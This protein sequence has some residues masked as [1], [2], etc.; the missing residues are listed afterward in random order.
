M[1][2]SDNDDE[3]SSI[4]TTT[5]KTHFLDPT[6]V[7]NLAKSIPN[8]SHVSPPVDTNTDGLSSTAAEDDDDANDTHGNYGIDALLSSTTKSRE[9]GGGAGESYFTSLSRR[10]QQTFSDGE[11]QQEQQQQEKQKQQQQQQ[12][13]ERDDETILSFLVSD[14]YSIEQLAAEAEGKHSS[15]SELEGAGI[16]RIDVYCRSGT[17]CT[18]RVIQTST[19]ST[20]DAAGS[21]SKDIVNDHN[22]SMVDE[23]LRD[24][25]GAEAIGNPSFLGMLRTPPKDNR[26]PSKD[27]EDHSSTNTTGGGSAN[28]TQVRRIVRRK[29]TLDALRRILEEPPH[30]PEINESIIAYN[31]DNNVPTTSG[32]G[33]DLSDNDTDDNSYIKTS[34][35]EHTSRAVSKLL[36]KRQQKRLSTKKFSSKL[37]KEQQAFLMKQQ[38]K[39][40]KRMKQDEKVRQHVGNAILMAGMEGYSG[41]EM[42]VDLLTLQSMSLEEDGTRGVGAGAPGGGGELSEKERSD[43]AVANAN[44]AVVVNSPASAAYRAQK[45]I[46]DKI[47][48][49]DMGLAILMGEAQRL[50][51]LMEAMKEPKKDGNEDDDDDTNTTGEASDGGGGTGDDDDEDDEDEDDTVGSRSFST[52]LSTEADNEDDD[53][54]VNSN[55]SNDYNSEMEDWKLARKLQGCEIE[56]SFPHEYHDE[57]ESALLN[58]DEDNSSSSD[59]ESFRRGRSPGSITPQMK[60][61]RKKKRQLKQR[62]ANVSPIVAVPTNGEGCV[63]LRQNGTFDVIGKIPE[64]LRKKLFRKKGPLPDCIALG[65]LGRYYVHFKDGS[66]FFYGP[67]ELS[68]ILVKNHRKQHRGKHRNRGKRGGDAET[69]VTVVSVAFGKDLDDFFVVRSDGSWESSGRMPSSLETLLKDRNHR[70]DLFWVSLG[71]NNEWCVRSKGGRVWWEGL[72]E[73]ADEALADILS[74]DSDGQLAFIDFGTDE[75]YFLLHR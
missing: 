65:T 1:S 41:S 59:D 38:Q 13:E 34:T 63:V 42:G 11:S 68:K 45:A 73:E 44:G 23:I 49:A 58:E 75:T 57:L 5:K 39:Y 56:Y 28:N 17:V 12:K 71:V 48:I 43:P 21:S 31:F 67:P 8:C 32:E 60:K 52:M 15:T 18:C 61:E 9:E 14:A 7:I 66:F 3:S 20:N 35:N 74:E 4:D 50:E 33:T 53:T 46:Q 64:T 37:S 2:D 22:V 54:S 62:L 27:K 19:S 69:T 51:R 72:S 36:R 24:S 26:Y 70:A 55:S 10:L 29:C 30:L 25:K 16:A 47:E 6:A 40:E